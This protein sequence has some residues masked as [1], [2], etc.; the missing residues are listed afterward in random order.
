MRK[1]ALQYLAAAA[2]ILLSLILYAA[3]AEQPK[4][5][6]P[7]A[8]EL[9]QPIGLHY[10]VRI[11]RTIDGDTVEVDLALGFDLAILKQSV[12]LHGI[13]CPE[14]NT[15]EGKAAAAYTVAWLQMHKPPYS[16][17]PM[18]GGRDKYGRLLGII[19]SDDDGHTLNGDL[20]TAG[21]AAIYK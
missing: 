20:L 12:R 14:K 4:A 16:L 7:A 17:L 6:A 5:P 10:P 19:S 15:P 1:T 2:P 21:H 11:L 18:E 9:K 8:A 3:V 13:N